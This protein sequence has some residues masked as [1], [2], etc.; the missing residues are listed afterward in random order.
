MKITKFKSWLTEAIKMDSAKVANE[1]IKNYLQKKLGGKIFILPPEEFENDFGHNYGIRYIFD[2]KKCVRFNWKSANLSSMNLVSVDI[3]D[4]SSSIAKYHLEFDNQVSLVKILPSIVDFINNPVANTT[5]TILPTETL[6]EDSSTYLTEASEF[7]VDVDKAYM[8]VIDALVPGE[9][10]PICVVRNE[11]GWGTKRIIDSLVDMFPEYFVLRGPRINF[12]VSRASAPIAIAK[13][14]SAK[15]NVLQSLGTI[16]AKVTT[17]K[18]EKI[19]PTEQEKQ[20]LSVGVK[21]IAYETQLQHLAKLIQLIVKGTSNSLFVA[22]RGGCL[23]KDTNI[24]I[25]EKSKIFRKLEQN[26]IDFFKYIAQEKFNINELEENEMYSIADQELFV[27]TPEGFSQVTHV[28]RKNLPSANIELDNGEFINCAQSHWVKVKDKGFVFANELTEDDNIETKDGY[29]GIKSL[30]LNDE[31]EDFYDISVQTSSQSFYTENG[32]CHHNTGKTQTVETELAKA[33][34]T[35][36]MGYFKNTGSVSPV[37]L[38]TTLYNNKDGIILFDD[39]DSALADIEGRNLIKTA[40]DTKK[41]RKIVWNK[42]S[43]FILPLDQYEKAM[44]ENE[45]ERPTTKTGDYMYPNQFEFTGRVIFISNLKLDKL[46]P[47]GA[48]RTRGFIIEIDPTDAELIDYMAKI[49]P[50]IRLESGGKLKQVDIDTVLNIIKNS[51]DKEPISLRKLVRGLN[52]IDVMGG[53]PMALEIIK[54]Y[55]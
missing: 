22:G 53:D 34:L 54:L 46:D 10:F 7:T 9:N 47:D 31:K 24:S 43:M 35:D 41:N 30:F 19:L 51:E 38:Y 4:G 15:A 20:I 11:C 12:N 2:G 23:D 25:Y 6:N 42:K 3:W 17:G 49:A 1:I 16:S 50:N 52:V 45:G 8:K 32:V 33:G 37:G 18:P 40:T 44:E 14:K 39:C 27:E 48:L 13:F 21:R 36:G 26:K 29:I 55:A 5:I 28:I